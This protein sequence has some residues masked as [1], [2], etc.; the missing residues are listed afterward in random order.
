MVFFIWDRTVIRYPSAIAHASS[1][2]GCGDRKQELIIRADVSSIHA[3]VVSIV[4]CRTE[5]PGIL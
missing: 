4:M 3:S 1:Q 2:M 5:P